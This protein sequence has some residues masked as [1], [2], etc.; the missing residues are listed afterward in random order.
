MLAQVLAKTGVLAGVLAQVLADYFVCVFHRAQLPDGTPASTPVFAGTPVFASTCAS[1]PAS[2]F[3]EVPDLGSVPGR[4]DLN[5][6]CHGF[7]FRPLANASMKR[8]LR[9]TFTMC[10]AQ[11]KLRG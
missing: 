4:R 9:G 1:T 2:T 11:R 8:A 3:S 6:R 5:L 10:L 7:T